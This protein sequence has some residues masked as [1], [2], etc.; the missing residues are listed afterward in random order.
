M[1]IRRGIGVSTGFAIGEALLLDREE[2]RVSRR[3]ILA[4]DADQEVRRLRE[5][6]DAA[7]AEI[8]GH[9]GSMPRKVREAAGKIL[10]AQIGWLQEKT[11]QDEI[12]DEVRRNLRSA[13][14]AASQVIRRKI[15]A[16]EDSNAAFAR[17]LATDFAELE[18]SF[19][20]HLQGSKREDVA[21]LTQP[22]VVVAHDLSPGQTLRLDRTKVLGL[23]TEVGGLTSHTAIVAKS[24]GIPAVVGVE[25][26]SNDITGGDTVVLDGASGTV[27]INPDEGTLKR[28][29]AMERNLLLLEKRRAKE[30]H[31]VP[32]ITRDG[33]RIEI[34]ANIESPE[35]IPAALEH[36]AEGI[37]LYRTE[38]LYLGGH[39][40]TEKDHLDAYMK[41]VSLLDRRRIIIRTLDLGADKLLE[42]GQ[43]R[44]ANPFLGTRAIRLCF[45]R[46]ELF[47][48][49]LR[50]ILKSASGGNVGLMIPMISSLTEVRQVKEA[51][52]DVR[53]ELRAAEE[54]A[55]EGMQVGIM[56]E[57]PSAAV[58][59]DQLA[60][61]VDFFSIGTNDLIAY[62]MAVDRSNERVAPLYQP[63]H[64]AVLRL[65]R[66]VIAAGNA[67]GKTVSVCGEMS[68]DLNFTLLLLGIGLRNFSVAPPMIPDLKKLIRSVSLNDAKGVAAKAF[69]FDDS[70][71][72]LEFLRVET[73]KFL[74]D[75]P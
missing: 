50:A 15:K 20:R 13:E 46:P 23:L 1:E 51:I 71:A 62:T 36:G 7:A 11:L 6:A 48:T 55:G 75:V 17:R 9:I 5:A 38:F 29:E 33:T 45:D 68:S 41:A 44:E 24:L 58:V 14:Y 67:A 19:L 42:D 54:P 74:S 37:G 30:L 59:A 40:P 63:A 70:A 22:V 4:K 47:R 66:Q 16:M 52:E 53:R 65:L 32:A 18:K 60:P 8:R 73:G 26:V 56:I 57:I 61:H 27:I 39:S 34:F 49:Q 3:P 64:P 72:T 35:E 31:D 21:H 2:F 12:A 28:Y 25:G 43:A 69:D 10:E